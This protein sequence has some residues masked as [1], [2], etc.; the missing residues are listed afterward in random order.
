VTAV[1]F[2]EFAA[3]FPE[4]LVLVGKDGALLALNSPAATLLGVGRRDLKERKLQDWA[5]GSEERLRRYLQACASTREFIP[6]CLVI[7]QDGAAVKYRCD[8][9]RLGSGADAPVLLRIR[10]QNESTAAFAKLNDRVEAM[11]RDIG[12]QRRSRAA[13]DQQRRWLQT[14]I[15]SIG[16][17]VIATDTAGRIVFMNP[18]AESLTGWKA[19]EAAGK[20][21]DTVFN[22]IDEST[23]KPA[24]NPVFR[25]LQEGVVVG[26]A[27][28]SALIR[29]DG[30]EFAIDDSAAPIR[31]ETDRAAGA[32]LVF[33]DVTEA[34]RREEQLRQ[35]QK[36]ES[37]GVLAGGIAHD[38]NN[39]LTGILGNASLAREVLPPGTE[40]GPML[41][42]V[43]TAC[44]RAAHLT[45]QMLAYSGKGRFVVG[46]VDVSA[47]VRDIVPL[48]QTS[49]SKKVRLILEL[50]DK[51]AVV[52][53]DGAQ[54]Q[55][56]VMNLVINAAESIHES[57]GMVVIRTARQFLREAPGFGP[58]AA[59][60]PPLAEPGE[61]VRLE[62]SDTGCGMDENVRQRMF[63]P[64]FTTKN[65]GRGLG[66]AAVIGIVNGHHGFLQVE[67]GVDRGTTMRVYLKARAE[68]ITST[69][70]TAAAATPP[71]VLVVDDEDI[72]RKTTT[73]ALE[74]RGYRI[75]PA[76]GGRE[77]IE[78]YRESSSELALVVL[79]M[80]LPDLNGDEVLKRL[81]A[82]RPGIPV[83]VC[84]GYA[85]VEVLRRFSGLE[86][87]G[88]LSKPYTSRQLAEAVESALSRKASTNRSESVI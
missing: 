4:A 82:I 40:A 74:R 51:P 44:E 28:H 31:G 84:S 41:D 78:R 3:V 9:A 72:V 8:G 30:A 12:E 49:I 76:R 25:A 39:L 56:L 24:V 48:L 63:D 45:R 5:P 59:Q 46:P 23:R 7:G 73:M 79:D 22:V 60:A 69:S 20:P 68:P 83:I 50:E 75:L 42:H 54:L 58:A 43:V 18:V 10:P 67:T 26:L 16:D 13:L 21:I 17:A 33:R 77:A 53:A 38:F 36:L 86:I 37:L 19:A 15:S 34:K 47:I 57:E 64:F 61:F 87:A 66:L 27:N 1:G 29:K 62:V 2:D 71:L 70:R 55:Q 35:T 85:D 65:T 80:I 14:T 6:G 32:V 11:V 88:V 52:E 81:N